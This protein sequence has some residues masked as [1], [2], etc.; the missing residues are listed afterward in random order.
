[1]TWHGQEGLW[2]LLSRRYR[3]DV[4]DNV[5]L[6]RVDIRRS[7]RSG[8]AVGAGGSSGGRGGVARLTTTAAIAAV[9]LTAIAAIA[10]VVLVLVVVVVVGRSG[11][12]ERLWLRRRRRSAGV[13]GRRSSRRVS[14]V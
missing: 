7:W 4:H 11:W 14:G 10:A 13:E 6:P 1:V 12:H 2:A 8:P 9:V 3:T 5:P